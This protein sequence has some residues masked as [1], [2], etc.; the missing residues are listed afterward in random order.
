MELISVRS[1]R[2]ERLQPPEI[3]ATEVAL[4]LKER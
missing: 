4:T 3:R 2:G 1:F